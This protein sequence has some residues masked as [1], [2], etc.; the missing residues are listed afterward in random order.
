MIA[1]VDTTSQTYKY[2]TEYKDL[3][4]VTYQLM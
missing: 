4:A 1:F 2:S 3:N